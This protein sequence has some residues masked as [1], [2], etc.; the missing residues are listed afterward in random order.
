MK[1][2]FTLF[3]IILWFVSGPLVN[4]QIKSRKEEK[5]LEPQPVV[6]VTTKPSDKKMYLGDTEV[7]INPAAATTKAQQKLGLVDLNKIELYAKQEIAGENKI[8][9]Y[10]VTAEREAKLFGVF[11]A[12]VAEKVE[13]NALNGP[14]SEVKTPWW[15]WLSF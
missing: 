13:I 2:F 3:T 8:P 14:V 9:A 5:V 7:M 12:G 15:S 1:I 4:A 6:M 11:K 10:Q